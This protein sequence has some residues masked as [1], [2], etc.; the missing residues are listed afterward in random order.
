MLGGI[1]GRWAGLLGVLLLWLVVF[2]ASQ[3]FSRV[4]FVLW[5]AI[6][7]LLLWSVRL[8]IYLLLHA[9]R[10]RGFNLRHVALV[11]AGP[12]EETLKRRLNSAGWS[13]YNI[14]LTVRATCCGRGG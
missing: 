7:L 4:W 8:A 3:D 12:V 14:A 10:R 6:A 11:G 2:K 9:I 5:P 13:G 1:A